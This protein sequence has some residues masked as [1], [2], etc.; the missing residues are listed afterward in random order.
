M[1]VGCSQG[2][3][4]QPAFLF[5]KGSQSGQ[6]A[7]ERIVASGVQVFHR[8]FFEIDLIEELR[9]LFRQFMREIR[10]EPKDG[11]IRIS[12]CTRRV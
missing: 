2:M 12:A 10:F 9:Q 8:I 6:V 3:W 5:L 4:Y 1:V 11:L 7:V